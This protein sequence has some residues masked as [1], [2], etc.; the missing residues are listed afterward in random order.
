[1]RGIVHECLVPGARD[2][3]HHSFSLSNWIIT[4]TRDLLLLLVLRRTSNTIICVPP[5]VREQE[6][7][8]ARDRERKRERERSLVARA[9]ARRARSIIVWRTMIVRFGVLLII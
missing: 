7:A 1:V 2:V 8:R 4:G 6:I 9:L 3:V 5:S